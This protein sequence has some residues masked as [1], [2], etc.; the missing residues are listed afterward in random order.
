MNLKKL[1][2]AVLITTLLV[3]S[4]FA[5]TRVFEVQETDFVK[6]KPDAIDKDYDKITY[7]FGPPLDADGEWQT[8]YGD[9]GTYYVNLTASD[10][11]SET[12]KEIKLV[13]HKKNRAPVLKQKKVSVK[14]SE[15]VSLKKYVEDPD[16]D[17]L[18]FTFPAPFDKTGKW[19]SS[20]D[21]AGT[22][23][24]EFYAND[25]EFNQKLRLEV[26][27]KEKNQPPVVMNLFSTEESLVAEEGTTLDFAIGAKDNDGDSLEYEWTW[28][29][30]KI[31]A[32][33][34]GS[35]FL[36][37]E[38]EG[39]H[40]LQVTVNDGVNGVEHEWKV[41]VAN[42]NRKPTFS[43]ENIAVKEGELAKITVP[44]KDVDGDTLKCTFE[45]P[46]NK[47]GEWQT[48]FTDAGV[49]KVEVVCT[50][51]EFNEINVVSV[52]VKNVDRAPTVAVPEVLEIREGEKG[53]WTFSAS[54]E[55]GDDVQLS[56]HNAPEGAQLK[57]TTFS[58]A[59]GYDAIKR[60]GNAVNN[61]L[62]S[63][64][65]EQKILKKDV[66][67]LTVEVCSKGLCSSEV[68]KLIVYNTNRKPTL[69]VP[70]SVT[71][72]E[73]EELMLKPSGTDPDSD[74]LR[75]FFTDPLGR[76]TGSWKT[77]FESEGDYTI[78][79]T[80]SDGSLE[81]SKDVD[82]KVLKKNRE[83]VLSI[84]ED[85]YIVLEGQEISF[86]VEA[87]DQ[88]QDDLTVTL[89]ELPPGA[90]FKDNVFTWTPS[91]DVI[92]NK[93]ISFRENTLSKSA[94]LTKYGSKNKGALWLK[95]TA[96]DGFAEAVHPVKLV[97]KD[98]NRAPSFVDFLPGP[99][100]TVYI[101]E[102]VVF[103]VAA[104]DLDGDALTYEWDFG[105]RQ[106]GLSDVNSVE[107]T[108]LS[109]GTKEVSVRVSDGREV[110]EKRWV[111]NV[112]PEALVRMLCMLLS[113]NL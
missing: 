13:V 56:V 52:V 73:T 68:T 42:T 1:V 34:E 55:D 77:H 31:H 48:D 113:I 81:A 12:V 29:G 111:V 58:W 110:I 36:D 47:K 11:K 94:W 105:F 15:T 41:S 83:P 92:Q 40:V 19:D 66:I 102:P 74:V 98:V 28:D 57:G 54:D 61:F 24:I 93:T 107:R 64:R 71:V 50:D 103:H 51:G 112:L 70:A 88:D 75:Y 35:Y 38:Q 89:E 14:E 108:F 84:P 27:I 96:S 106:D 25:G 69:N 99:N 86:K 10:G 59:P 62:N 97:V 46:F 49:V 85:E 3:S 9:A 7:T 18:T 2:L 53:E 23:V 63:I 104:V 60:R 43:L 6:I 109:A 91:F 82:V 21:D 79:V 101:N 5:A 33:A 26:E 90:S 30:E 39:E 8:S 16:D 72:V 87:T 4:V 76:R 22:R 44:A 67:P 17:P 20:F 95:F 45:R 37:F 100:T 80:A 65:V 78:T 32:K